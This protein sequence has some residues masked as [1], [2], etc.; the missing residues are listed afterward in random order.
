L[1]GQASHYKIGQSLVTG[2]DAIQRLHQIK[3]DAFTEFG[4]NQQV[5][6]GERKILG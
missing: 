5:L 4:G 3:N 1:F 2:A 6:Y